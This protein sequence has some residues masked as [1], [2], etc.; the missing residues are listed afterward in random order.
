LLASGGVKAPIPGD[1]F[2]GGEVELDVD[3]GAIPGV[4]TTFSTWQH[5]AVVA[6]WALFH[7]NATTGQMLQVGQGEL[8]QA[9]RILRGTCPS[10][11]IPQFVVLDPQGIPQYLEHPAAIKLA[12]RVLVK[13]LGKKADPSENR[14]GRRTYQRLTGTNHTGSAIAWA[15]L[16]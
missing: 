9:L 14:W 3:I 16:L 12:R 13:L 11:L 15:R 10:C 1:E 2:A 8:R 7:Q 4:Q 6:V 5:F